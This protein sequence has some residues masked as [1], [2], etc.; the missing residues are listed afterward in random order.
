[1]SMWKSN[2]ISAVPNQTGIPSF[3][4]QI[5]QISYYFPLLLQVTNIWGVNFK[6][7]LKIISASWVIEKYFSLQTR[8]NSFH[9]RQDLTL[10][11]WLLELPVGTNV[12]EKQK[13]VLVNVGKRNQC[14]VFLSGKTSKV[15]K[16]FSEE[17]YSIGLHKI[18]A[19][20][21]ANAIP[22]IV[23]LISEYTHK[24]AQKC[25]FRY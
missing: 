13:E 6:F 14:L 7:F 17:A 9:W 11:E 15:N 20:N 18:I 2:K 21:P 23:L 16:S 4:N 25:L 22:W 1:M 10:T 8:K 12:K 5:S 3:L 24:M 19:L